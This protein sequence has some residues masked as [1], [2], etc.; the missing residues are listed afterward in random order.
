[1]PQFSKET[2]DFLSKEGVPP[3]DE[4]EVKKIVRPCPA[5]ASRMVP[6]DILIFR[7]WLGAGHGLGPI[8]VKGSRAQKVVLIVSCG[9][10]N[11][12][13]PGRDGTLVSCVKLE[14]LSEAVLDVLLTNLYKKQVKASRD[15]VI[16]YIA[17]V[18]GSIDKLTG[19]SGDFRT[20]KLHKMKSIFKVYLGED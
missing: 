6:G 20:Y 5:S 17:E 15:Q 9:R 8:G 19:S 13:F 4:G 3:K 7:Y 2:Q 14:V 1:M 16:K 18:K 12:A 11:G 10:G